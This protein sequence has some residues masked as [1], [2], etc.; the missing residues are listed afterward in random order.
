VNFWAKV[1][2]ELL[3]WA[4][5]LLQAENLRQQIYRLKNENEILR[6]ALSDIQRM[7]HG[8]RISEYAQRTLKTLG[9]D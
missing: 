1:T 9:D 5:S 4:M 8:G 7:D 2:G 3:S 6:T